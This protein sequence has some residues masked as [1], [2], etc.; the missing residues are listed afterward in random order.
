MIK[1]LGTIL[2]TAALMDAADRWQDQHDAAAL[3]AA[4][5]ELSGMGLLRKVVAGE[6]RYYDGPN[7][8]T[9][10]IKRSPREKR[11]WFETRPD[12]DWSVPSPFEA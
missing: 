5:K 12:G 8:Y 2:P 7:I 10:A 4:E 3:R 11:R 6:V 1:T 9:I